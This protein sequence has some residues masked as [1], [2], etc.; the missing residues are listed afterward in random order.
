[1]PHHVCRP[2]VAT[3]R[4]RSGSRVPE[5]RSVGRQWKCQS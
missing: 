4:E 3:V 5:R 1:M 2:R